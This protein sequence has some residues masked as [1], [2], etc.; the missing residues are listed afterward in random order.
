M[1]R[2]YLR[3]LPVFAGAPASFDPQSAPEGPVELFAQ[4]LRYAVD[5][6]VPEPHAM[7]LSTCDGAGM[8]DGRV[9]ILKDL[10]ERGWWF[11][12]NADSA[13][14]IQLAESRAAA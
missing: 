1:M 10:D 8:P 11:A 2:D 5:E 12:A 13:K 6:G 14:G 9:L 4:W 7:T 3:S